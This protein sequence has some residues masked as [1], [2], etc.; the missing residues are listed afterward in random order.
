MSMQEVFEVG[1][2]T[3]IQKLVTWP[4]GGTLEITLGNTTNDQCSK[5]FEQCLG[6][7]QRFQSLKWIYTYANFQ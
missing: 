1:Y 3:W 6:L 7:L 2:E 4:K 5:L